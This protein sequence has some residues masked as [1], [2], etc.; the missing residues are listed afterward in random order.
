MALKELRGGPVVL[1]FYP[2]DDTETCT[3]EA[4]AFRDAFPRFEGLGATV[5][6]ISPDGVRSHARFR[7]RYGL[8]YALLADTEHAVAARYGV[9]Q[10]KVLFGRRYMGVVRTTF[11]VD[12]E[13]RIARVFEKV[14]VAGHAE[15][16]AEAVAQLQGRG[17]T[18]CEPVVSFAPGSRS[19]TPDDSGHD[20]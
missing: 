16:V 15:A 14:R 7:A 1:F 17:H 4:C 11:V 6:G 3:A 13:G 9:W 12:A 19:S 2:R 8:P 18:S 5:L 10:E 20:R